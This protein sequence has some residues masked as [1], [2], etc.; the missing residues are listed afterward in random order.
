MNCVAKA[1]NKLFPN[2]DTS[3]FHN[4]TLG[5]GMGDIQRMI[6]TELSVWPVY[7][8]HY[9]TD[10]KKYLD[11]ASDEN[12]TLTGHIHGLWTVQKGMLNVGCDAWHFYPVSEEEVLFKYNAMQK[13]YDTNV[14]VYGND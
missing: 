14:F 6:P 3:E 8:N 5:V 11:H 7:C 10:C 9:P 12:F 1:V 4:R 13:I 2:Q